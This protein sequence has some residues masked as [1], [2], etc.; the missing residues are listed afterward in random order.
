MVTFLKR[1]IGLWREDKL[2]CE[3]KNPIMEFKDEKE[4]FEYINKEHPNTKN[5]KE[6]PLHID[7]ES[8]IQWTVIGYIKT[9]DN[10]WK[11]K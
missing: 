3:V 9:K 2:P 1:D 6:Y 7:G 10:E 11:F 4:L 8:V 5:D